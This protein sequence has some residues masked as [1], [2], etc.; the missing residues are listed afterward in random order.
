MTIAA[1]ILAAVYV[2]IIFEVLFMF[3]LL[4]SSV[5]T[6]KCVSASWVSWMGSVLPSDQT[7]EVSFLRLDL[8]LSLGRRL[9]VLDICSVL[10]AGVQDGSCQA[11]AT[12]HRRTVNMHVISSHPSLM[13]PK[14]DP[15]GTS[16]ECWGAGPSS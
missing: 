4:D 14:C 5:P 12:V 9:P 16:V 13:P 10:A 15:E 3:V 8:P 6:S 1:A 2:L 11:P 7:A